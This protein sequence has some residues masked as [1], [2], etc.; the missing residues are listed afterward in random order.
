[1]S[2]VPICLHVGVS[3]LP[4]EAS[5]VS[6]GLTISSYLLFFQGWDWEPQTPL[7]IHAESSFES[8]FCVMILQTAK[9]NKPRRHT[10]VGVVGGCLYLCKFSLKVLILWLHFLLS[11][12]CPN[13]IY[14]SLLSFTFMNLD[15]PPPLFINGHSRGSFISCRNDLVVNPKAARIWTEFALLILFCVTVNITVVALCLFVTATAKP[16]S[17]ELISA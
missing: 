8:I 12:L 16:R 2:V 13:L 1:M 5:V 4:S 7:F 9:K 15:P 17:L 14:P 6:A 10:S 3:T 11:F